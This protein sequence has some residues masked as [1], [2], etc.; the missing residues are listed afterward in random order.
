MT[1]LHP[2]PRRRRGLTDAEKQ[3]RAERRAERQIRLAIARIAA[4]TS[5]P[6]FRGAAIFGAIVAERE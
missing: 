3:A 5:L 4:R 6:R 2:S 1:A